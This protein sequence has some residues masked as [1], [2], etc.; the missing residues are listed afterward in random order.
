M[1]MHLLAA[2]AVLLLGSRWLPSLCKTI[3]N[4]HHVSM[5]AQL[6]NVGYTEVTVHK[7]G[8]VQDPCSFAAGACQG[9][10]ILQP[11]TA[12]LQSWREL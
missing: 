11:N 3:A 5:N 2:G 12:S 7:L 4:H 9:M 6:H 8:F 10:H 1:L